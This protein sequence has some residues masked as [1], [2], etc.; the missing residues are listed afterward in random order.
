MR[1]VLLA[2][3]LAACAGAPPPELPAPVLPERAG[4][5]P[6]VAAR[7]EGIAFRAAG[8]GFVLDIF[9]EERIRLTLTKDGEVLV[10]PKT[11]PRYPA[12]MGSIYLTHNDAHHLRITIRDY[13]DCEGPEGASYRSRVEIRLDDIVLEGCGR[14]L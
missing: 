14:A 3:L 4:V 9:N 6:L 2:V 13:N 1:A 7:A 8:D 12:W 10:F 5:D 11:E